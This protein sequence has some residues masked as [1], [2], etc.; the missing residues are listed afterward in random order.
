MQQQ[1]R[2]YA[3]DERRGKKLRAKLALARQQSTTIRCEDARARSHAD[4]MPHTK[5]PRRVIATF[6]RNDMAARMTAQQSAL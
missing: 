6:W 4:A 5:A 3:V 2:L 1:Q